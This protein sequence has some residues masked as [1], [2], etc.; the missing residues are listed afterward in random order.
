MGYGKVEEKYKWWYDLE[1]V[2]GTWRIPPKSKDIDF[3]DA[4]R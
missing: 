1:D 4:E 3:F 2:S